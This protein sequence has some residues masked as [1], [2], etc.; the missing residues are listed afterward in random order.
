M[1]EKQKDISV[2]GFILACVALGITFF[3]TDSRQS[4]ESAILFYFIAL[5]SQLIYYV[6]KKNENDETWSNQDIGVIFLSSAL[7]LWVPVMLSL[8]LE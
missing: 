8:V 2:Q 6:Y 5:V 1:K 7:A 4:F 3:I